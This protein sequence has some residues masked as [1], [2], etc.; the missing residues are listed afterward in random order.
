MMIGEL[1]ASLGVSTKTL[2]LYEDRGLIPAPSRAGNGYRIYRADAV[3]RARLLVNL[4][5]LGLSLDEIEHLMGAFGSRDRSL[6]RELSG[7]LHERFRALAEEIAIRQG[8]LD[9][10]EARYLALVGTP[11]ASGPDCVCAAVN[12]VC[13][14]ETGA[15][16]HPRK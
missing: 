13:D 8:Q 10:V 15:L 2:R 5:S 11:R 7:I 3:Q 14:C 6:R 1:A 12:R 4:R 9:D 16:A